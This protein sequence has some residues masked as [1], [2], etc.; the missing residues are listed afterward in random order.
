MGN[1]RGT[2]NESTLNVSALGRHVDSEETE[3]SLRARNEGSGSIV[4]PEL[5]IAVSVG[6]LKCY[7]FAIS[8]YWFC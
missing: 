6:M 1:N 3:L 7:A 2:R 5:W 8:C 4:L